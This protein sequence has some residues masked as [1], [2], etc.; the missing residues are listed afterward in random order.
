MMYGNYCQ[1][2]NV[3]KLFIQTKVIN[4]AKNKW[5]CCLSLQPSGSGHKP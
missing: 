1:L 3:K 2:R 5:H 4:N